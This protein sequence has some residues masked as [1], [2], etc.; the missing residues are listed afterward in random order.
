MISWLIKNSLFIIIIFAWI[1]LSIIWE[2]TRRNKGSL[3][4][5]PLVVVYYSDFLKKLIRK[6]GFKYKKFWRKLGNVSDK[7]FIFALLISIIYVTL[8]VVA[9][10]SGAYFEFLGIPIGS[11]FIV[12]VPFITIPAGKLLVF[13]IFGFILALVFHELFHG[14][15]SIAEDVKIKSAGIIISLGVAGGFV[16][17]NIEDELRAILDNLEQRT[18][19]EGGGRSAS[20][21]LAPRAKKILRKYRRIVAAGIIANILLVSIFAG[22]LIGFGII[23]AYEKYGLKILKVE[24]GSPADICGLRVGDII[25]MIAEKRVRTLADFQEILSELSPGENV[26]FKVLRNNREV[27][28]YVV[29]GEKNGRPYVGILIQQYIRSNIPFLS[30]GA[31]LDLHYFLYINALLEFLVVVINSLPIF[32]LDGS[33]WLNASLIEKYGRRGLK[34]GTTIN[35]IITLIFILNFIAPTIT[36]FLVQ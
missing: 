11:Q 4:I 9:L 3:R 27:L 32:F 35:I 10:F 2:K 12:V 15:V 13:I 24:E 30:D 1:L 21:Q 26:S 17:P 16:E 5:Y 23:G 33:Q 29:L 7:I 14:V 6:V 34:I 18:I 28:I 22:L 31:A 8:N 19:N 36:S 20:H 25:V